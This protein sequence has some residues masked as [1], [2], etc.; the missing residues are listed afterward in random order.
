MAAWPSALR[1][2]MNAG[3]CVV[4]R[5]SQAERAGGELATLNRWQD[6]FDPLDGPSIAVGGK[7]QGRL[8]VVGWLPPSWQ[9]APALS[10]YAV[11][12]AYPFQPS[13]ERGR[14]E[15]GAVLS[16]HENAAVQGA[17]DSGYGIVPNSETR[18]VCGDAYDLSGGHD[19]LQAERAGSDP[20]GAVSKGSTLH[21]RDEMGVQ[22]L[23]AGI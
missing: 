4:R 7:A 12:P 14:A 17:Q 6:G 2:G 5:V 9:I 18:L 19:Y 8:Q 23:R 15:R 10:V 3:D 20:M 21:A 13:G 11:H 1:P 22:T 16:D